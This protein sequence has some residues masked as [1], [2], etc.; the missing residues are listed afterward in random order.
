MKM[1]RYLLVVP[2]TGLVSPYYQFDQLEFALIHA[3]ALGCIIFDTVLGRYIYM[4]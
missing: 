1:K 3:D 2:E 4:K